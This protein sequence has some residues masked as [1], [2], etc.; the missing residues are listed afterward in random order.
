[1][2]ARA[3]F[4]YFKLFAGAVFVMLVWMALGISLLDDDWS[5]LILASKGIGPALTTGW[6]GLVGQGGYYRP[7]VVLSF[8]LDYLIGGY[9]PAIYHIHNILIHAGCASLVFLL[10]RSLRVERAGA[11]GSALLFFVLPIHTDSVFWI[12]GRTDLLC[13]LFYFGALLVFQAYL[14]R[15]SLLALFALAAC[16]TLAFCSKEM[17][18]SLPIALAVWIAHRKAWKNARTWRGMAVVCGALLMYFAVRYLVLGSALGGTPRVSLL[19]WMWDGAK[20]IA[21]FGMTDIWW[22]GIALVIASAGIFIFKSRRETRLILPL[23]GLVAASLAPALGH[24]H[25]WYLYLPSAF[26]SVGIAAVWLDKRRPVC[27]V[28]FCVLIAY[29]GLVLGREGMFWRQASKMS[30]HVLADLMPHAQRTTSTLFA[31]NVPAAW[32]PKGAFSGKPLFAYA[33]KNALALRSAQPL[34]A[35]IEMVN[36]VWLTGDFESRVHRTN[37]GFDLAI[38][39]GGFFSFHGKGQGQTPPFAIVHPWG[40]LTVHALDSLSVS[41]NAQPGDRVV[42]YNFDPP[43]PPSH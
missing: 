40:T 29:Y 42:I 41:L 24:L 18:I 6:Q 33:L 3:I 9:E 28:I 20:A 43:N 2:N 25:N 1:M 7:V 10:A 5:H 11:W 19:N 15:G 39:K 37:A 31:C 21:K 16:S 23:A 26:F 8:Y 12:V 30:E 38:A 13:A 17:A 35:Q 27:R 32:T 34:H 4:V 36:H 22:L 14:Q